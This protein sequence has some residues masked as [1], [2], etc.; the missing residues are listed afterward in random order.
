MSHPHPAA[1][2][3][4]DLSAALAVVT[5][6]VA[7]SRGDGHFWDAVGA[8]LDDGFTEEERDGNA[9]VLLFG[10]IKLAAILA[11]L[12][13]TARRQPVD[14]LLQEVAIEAA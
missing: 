6:F 1:S 4:T 9:A 8:I 12:A 7:Q 13:A 11:D 10:L 5:A 14:A 2:R 3:P